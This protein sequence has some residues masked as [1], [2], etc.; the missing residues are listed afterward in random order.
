[1]GQI[2]PALM[3]ILAAATREQHW[4]SEELLGHNLRELNNFSFVPTCQTCSHDP[5]HHM[6]LCSSQIR[7][8]RA[9]QPSVVGYSAHQSLGFLGFFCSICGSVH[10]SLR[11][12]V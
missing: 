1:M 11:G 3:L 6:R 2:I 5:Q 10:D 12:S 8:M 9:L 7:T 4:C